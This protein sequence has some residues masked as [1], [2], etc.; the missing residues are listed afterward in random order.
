VS[1]TDEECYARHPWLFG[2]AEFEDTDDASDLTGKLP[3][4]PASRP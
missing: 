4:G 1:P 3:S 2:L